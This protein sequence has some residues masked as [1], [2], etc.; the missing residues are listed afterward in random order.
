MKRLFILLT[1]L[2][3]G[4]LQILAQNEVVFN[5]HQKMGEQS[6]QFNV[7]VKNNL[8]N[9]FEFTRLQYYISEISIIH[10]GG[11]KTDVE[12][13]WLLVSADQDVSAS[14]GV[15]NIEEVEAIHFYI[16]VD[17]GHNHANPADYPTGH[18]LAPQNPSMHW[19][20]ASGYR[21]IALEGKGSE[22]LNQVVQLH[23]LWDDNYLLSRLFS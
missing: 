16:G 13:F 23:G 19:G 15:F 6:F 1:L 20:W 21:F 11:Q 12:D 8:G 14:L 3:Y 2:N 5:I 22:N 9:D 4:F 10:D 7:P 17:P 18:P